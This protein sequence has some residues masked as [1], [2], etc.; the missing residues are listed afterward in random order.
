MRQRLVDAILVICALAMVGLAA[1]NQFGPRK[2]AGAQQP[3][4]TKVA[5]W[6]KYQDGTRRA[7]AVTAPI[8]IVVFSDYQC[9]FCRT[10]WSA[11]D[12]L[13][14]EAPDSIAITV[15]HFPLTG[16]HPQARAASELAEC[17]RREGRFRAADSLLFQW[18]DTVKAERWESVA[19]AIGLQPSQIAVCMKSVEIAAR[20]DADIAAASSLGATGTPLVLINDRRVPGL[21]G[22]AE[23]RSIAKA[24]R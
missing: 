8:S 13:A 19:L 12:S 11:L 17:A 18:P 9:P 7:G 20:I 14:R 16:I 23:L 22:L 2:T 21:V 6:R 10:L 4:V 1:A 5:E 15:R 3:A 24:A